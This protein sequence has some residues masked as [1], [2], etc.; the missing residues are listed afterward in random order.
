[1]LVDSFWECNN[2]N[3]NNNNNIDNNNKKIILIGEPKFLNLEK[4]LAFG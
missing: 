3:N 1:M 4:C 2:N